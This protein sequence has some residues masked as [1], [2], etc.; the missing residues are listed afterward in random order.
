MSQFGLLLVSGNQTHQE[1]YARAFAADP[2]CRLV[3]LTDEPTDPR[4]TEL[5]R[6]LAEELNIP[7]LE[8]F[9]AAVR[10]DDVD[11]VSI[12]SEPERRLKLTLECVE[13]GKHVYF[14]KDPAPTVAE[15]RQIAE[16]VSK[17]GLLSQAF[18]LVRVPAAA[19]AKAAL[20]SGELGELIGLHCDITFAKGTAGTATLG[21]RDEKSNPTQFSFFDSKREFFCVGYYA[22]A[23]FQWLTGQRFATVDAT[24]SNY[25][26]TEHQKNDV[27]DFSCAMLGL[28]NGVEA[29]ITAGRCGWK[30][31]LTHGIHD[32]LLVGTKGSLTLDAYAPRLVTFSDAEPWSPPAEPHPEDPMGF[33]S[34]TTKASG[35][36]PKTDWQPIQDAAKS[37]AVCFL[38]CLES[39]TQSDMPVELAAH[40]VEV[41]HAVYESASTGESVRL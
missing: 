11:F 1:N 21:R 35:V 8:D 7:F 31:H 27:E 30:S 36:L 6:A 3:G 39:G 15:A 25:F 22:V 33:W 24:T 4:R 10:R 19:Q 29:T 23:F 41:V 32:I 26:F 17:R 2:R 12:C 14:D 13:A 38:D 9:S 28:E 34:S 40:S 5:N 16:A 37:D 20:D 18:S